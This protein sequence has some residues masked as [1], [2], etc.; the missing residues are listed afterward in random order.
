MNSIKH[1]ISLERSNLIG[2][3]KGMSKTTFANTCIKEL[4]QSGKKAVP[5]TALADLALLYLNHIKNVTSARYVGLNSLYTSVKYNTN[6][7][8]ESSENEE[9]T[10]EVA[11][12]LKEFKWSDFLSAEV[13]FVELT[14]PHTAALEVDL[15]R[16]LLSSRAKVNKPTIC[17]IN[18]APASYAYGN[19]LATSF[20][21]EYIDRTSSNY[22]NYG[23][24]KHVSCFVT[25]MKSK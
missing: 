17:T 2:S 5:Y 19:H 20:F 9:E 16:L 7:E 14:S 15:L 11:E 6:K 8:D 23:S 12:Y 3:P 4:V 10:L 22:R 1:G 24:L 25:N 18:I 13:L 21:N